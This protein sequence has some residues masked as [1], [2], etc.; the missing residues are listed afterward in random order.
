MGKVW[1]CALRVRHPHSLIVSDLMGYGATPQ[2]ALKDAKD[3]ALYRKEKLEDVKPRLRY[4]EE[5]AVTRP[6]NVVRD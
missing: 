5:I 6:T 3:V 2:A 4:V 1:Q